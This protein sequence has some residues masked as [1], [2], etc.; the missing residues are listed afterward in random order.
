MVRRRNWGLAREVNEPGLELGRMENGNFSGIEE[1]GIV[2]SNGYCTF[3]M[4]PMC[5]SM[6]ISNSQKMSCFS[7]VNQIASAHVVVNVSI[8]IKFWILS[9]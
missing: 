8:A 2:I 1:E 5:N 3:N 6:P 4:D 9:I 7:F